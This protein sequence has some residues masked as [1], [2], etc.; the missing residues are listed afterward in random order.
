VTDLISNLENREL[1]LGVLTN[2]FA[3]NAEI[4][5]ENWNLLHQF[6]AIIDCGKI[7]AFKPM[8]QPFEGILSLLDV[9]PS[10]ALFVGD[11]YYAD[12][13]GGK[14]VGL[15]TVWINHREHSLEDLIAKYGAE[16]TPDYVMYSMS[17]FAD[18]L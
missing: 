12:M 5:L 9:S 7:Q 18:L 2:S 15:T 10:E 11:E 3:G 6:Q 13:V 8:P 16:K 17:E 14:S 1:K 4:I